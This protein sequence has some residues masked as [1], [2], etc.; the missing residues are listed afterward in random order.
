MRKELQD[1]EVKIQLLQAFAEHSRERQ[2]DDVSAVSDDEQNE[3]S[4]L[5]S[6]LAKAQD[7]IKKLVRGSVQ[8]DEILNSGRPVNLK[9]DLGYEGKGK[10]HDH[11]IN[12]VRESGY[13]YMEQNI[14][15]T[16][17]STSHHHQYNAAGTQNSHPARNYT[18]RQFQPNLYKSDEPVHQNGRKF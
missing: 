1:A 17:A 10:N 9:T 14:N 18:R 12:F 5:S 7:K 8:L 11:K 4:R 15:Y 6:E 3:V 13:R 2:L 16:D